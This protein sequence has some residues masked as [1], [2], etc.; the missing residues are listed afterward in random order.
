[1]IFHAGPFEGKKILVDLQALATHL[2]GT[3]RFMSPVVSRLLD[4]PSD[5]G[6]ETM[7]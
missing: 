3:C 6:L 7:I 5:D 4:L 1:M 2:I